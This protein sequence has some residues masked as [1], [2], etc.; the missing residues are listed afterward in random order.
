MRWPVFAP[1]GREPRQATALGP[2]SGRG[3]LAVVA[4]WVL[5]GGSALAS[6]VAPNPAPNAVVVRTTV[7]PLWPPASTSPLSSI[8]AGMAMVFSP[9]FSAPG[10]RELYERMGFL[11][12]ERA[13]W[14]RVLDTIERFNAEHP[15]ARVLAVF[16]TCHGAN[17]NGLKLQ[18][19]HEPGDERSYAS[20][21]GLQERLGRAGVERCVLA[22]C[23]TG[24]L[25]RPEIYNRLDP[26][27][28]DPLFAPPSEASINANPG[29]DPARST[30][31]VIRRADNQKENTSEGALSELS[32]TTRHALGEPDG[33]S[34]FVVSDLF[35]QMLTADPA[36]TLTSRGYVSDIVL[37]GADNERSDRYFRRFVQVLDHIA[38][39]ASAAG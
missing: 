31:E 21:G 15:D 9:D 13:S 1:A 34:R 30:V 19:G 7:A 32:I 39:R 5:L 33:H 38:R 25:F 37:E 36:L 12:V 35:V 2:L 20:I 17:G 6:G 18:S 27:V 4:G 24:R 22:A 8:G 23:N 10:N 28:R 16:V 29:F 3:A 11:Y 26:D 14:A